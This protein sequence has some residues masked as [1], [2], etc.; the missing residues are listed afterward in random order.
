MLEEE[1]SIVLHHITHDKQQFKLAG[2]QLHP[3]TSRYV[4]YLK[5]RDRDN[6]VY[7]GNELILVTMTCNLLPCLI[8]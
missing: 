6:V 8:K 3:H 2:H 1:P 4:S 5:R 7:G